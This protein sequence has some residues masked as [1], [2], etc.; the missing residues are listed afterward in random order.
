MVGLRQS[1]ENKG[2]NMNIL[3]SGLA[4]GVGLLLFAGIAQAQATGPCPQLPADSGLTWTHQAAPAFDFCKAMRAD[5]TQALGVFIGEESPFE[6]KGSNRAEAGTIEGQPI[7]WYRGE[8]AG[9]PNVQV[10]ETLVELGDD[11]VAHIWMKARNPQELAREMALAQGLRFSDS[12]ISG[13]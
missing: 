11:R 6:P 9:D 12:R 1:Q 13:R 8:L 7:Y 3:T 5:G 4:S 2:E 10:R